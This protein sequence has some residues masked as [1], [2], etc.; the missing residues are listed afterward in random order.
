MKEQLIALAHRIC[1]E[2]FMD[3]PDYDEDMELDIEDAI[4]I[5]IM[6]SVPND[7]DI[8]SVDVY[9]FI[10]LMKYTNIT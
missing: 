3:Y 2:G 10:K 6:E 8:Q 4:T 5:L 7:S 1:K 9:D